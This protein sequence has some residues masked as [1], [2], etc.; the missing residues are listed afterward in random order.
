MVDPLRIMRFARDA[1]NHP[2]RG[3]R[4]PFMINVEL[5]I[6]KMRMSLIYDRASQLE[7]GLNDA[8]LD[9]DKAKILDGH[10]CGRRLI[11]L[12]RMRR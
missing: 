2:A 5:F 3:G 9:M 8:S 12:A 1:R 4:Q 10:R 11:G 7:S 6:P